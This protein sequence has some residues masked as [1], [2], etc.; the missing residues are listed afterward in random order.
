MGP[1]A[2][3]ALEGGNIGFQLGGRATDFVL[4]VVNPSAR[5]VMTRLSWAPMP[6]LQPVPRAELQPLPPTWLCGLRFR[7]FALA[8]VVCRG[9]T[10]GLTSMARTKNSMA[11]G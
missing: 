10:R 3:Y 4:L 8:W 7:L 9:L 2:M 1:P 5:N 11:A 6:P